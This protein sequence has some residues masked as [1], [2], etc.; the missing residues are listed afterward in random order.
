PIEHR[1]AEADHRTADDIGGQEAEQRQADG[2][3]KNT[4]AGDVER[5]IAVGRQVL[6]KQGLH[7]TVDRVDDEPRDIGCNGH[8][9]EHDEAGE[10]PRPQLAPER[11]V[12]RSWR[13]FGRHDAALIAAQQWRRAAANAR[14]RTA[15][16]PYSY[17]SPRS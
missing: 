9:A 6:G 13:G 7:P 16:P 14:R 17:A 8:R 3:D 10:E 2:A 5:Q 1:L 4:Q 12:E 15:L 11:A